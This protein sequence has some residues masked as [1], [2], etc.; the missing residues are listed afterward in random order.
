M[1]CINSSKG[2]TSTRPAQK[3]SSRAV[4]F[5]TSNSLGLAQ[6]PCDSTLESRFACEAG[7]FGST[8]EE[9]SDTC[10]LCHSLMH[11]SPF[12]PKHRKQSSG[13]Q[14]CKCLPYHLPSAHHLPLL[15]LLF[16]PPKTF[17]LQLL[18]SR[19]VHAKT[20]ACCTRQADKCRPPVL[21]QAFKK[22][23]KPKKCITQSTRHARYSPKQPWISDF[24]SLFLSSIVPIYQSWGL[25]TITC[26]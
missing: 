12:W 8:A 24:C 21:G 25:V 19:N 2:Q 16:I 1:S 17:L 15:F 5:D 26:V 11:F 9:P 18:T 6:L 20:Q 13:E 23:K 3:E 7:K 22:K 14:L 10:W 4:L